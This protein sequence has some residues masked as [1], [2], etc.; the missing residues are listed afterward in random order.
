MTLSREPWK[1][2]IRARS[3]TA[4]SS[5]AIAP[6]SPKPPR[7][8]DG[9]NENVAAF[10]N[11]PARRPA[12]VAPAACAASSSDRHAERLDLGDR[13]DVAE[14]VD[15]DHRLRARRQRRAHGLGGDAERLRVDVAEDRARAPVGGIASALA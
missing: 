4:S 5:V 7:F 10:P 13:R 3:A 6:P 9:K 8:F 11:E 14:Q 12:S 2:S 1:R 15:G